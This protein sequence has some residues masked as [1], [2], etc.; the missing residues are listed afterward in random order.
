MR[1]AIIL[2][3]LGGPDS[4]HA[5]RPFLENLFSDPAIVNLPR[6]VR[7]P[8]AKAIA[9]K[10]ER[11]A[12]HIY[13]FMG[14]QS[15]LLK[16]TVS[17]ANAL[18]K[19]LGS[20]FECFVC[21]RYWH[22]MTSEVVTRVKTYD[23]HRVILL[24][25]YPQFST[26]TTGSSFKAW[27]QECIVHS[28]QVPTLEIPYYPTQEGFIQAM[29]TL[30][31]EAIETLKVKDAFRILFTAH[32]LP[33]SIVDAGDP[34]ADQVKQSVDKILDQM[35]G[36]VDA[37]IAYQSKVGPVK[38]LKPYT[39]QEIKRAGKEGKSLIVVPVSF[40]SEHSETLVELDIQYK[41]L[42]EIAG[43]HKY[44]RVPTVSTHP[45]FIKGLKDLVLKTLDAVPLHP[46]S[47]HL[48]KESPALDSE[49]AAS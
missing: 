5:V 1:T 16:N 14:G 9:L 26:T 17:Q 12:Q 39:E 33:Q 41:E 8:L 19:E 30:T 28:F 21:M 6:L 3:N 11:E 20:G 23:P 22:P 47:E 48:Q 49:R 37:L 40:V 2:F 29:A 7:L 4:P 34:Y 42:A 46:A 10:R 36:P 25:L 27:R 18:S 44:I 24:P 15:P 35:G 31:Q 38:W 13:G 32:G 43:V 45:L